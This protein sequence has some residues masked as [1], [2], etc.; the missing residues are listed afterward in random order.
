VLSLERYLNTSYSPDCEY[1][2][3]ALVERNVGERAHARI[4]AA[5]GGYIRSHE[6]HWGVKAYMSLH[7]QVREC[8]YAIPDLCIY[9]R[10]SFDER[11]PSI[12]PLLWI[13]ILSP[14]DRMADV[15]SRADELIRNGVPHIWIIEPHTL[16]SEL[17]TANGVEK[18]LDKTLRLPGS[19]IVIPLLDVMDE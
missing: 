10:G 17:R 8:W 9:R 6:R 2:D 15:W 11:Y 14:D 16:E 3:G 1:W 19:P 4:Q 7:I 5:L 12:Q 13:E 18:L